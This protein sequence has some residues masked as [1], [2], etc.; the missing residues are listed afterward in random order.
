MIPYRAARDRVVADCA[1]IGTETLAIGD[2]L[3]R[4]LAEAVVAADPVPPFANTAMDGYAV[5]AADV[6]G[7][8]ATEPARLKVIGTLAAGAAPTAAVAPGEALR[9]M[10]GAPFPSGADAIVHRRGHRG[11]RRRRAGARARGAGEFIRAAGRGHR[12]RVGG[13]RGPGRSSDLDISGCWPVSG[14]A[15]V[16]VF[17]RR[18]GRGA[19]DRRRAG[20]ASGPLRLGQIR[21]SNRR[22]LLALLAPGRVRAGR[23]GHRPGRRGRPSAPPSRRPWPVRRRPDQRWGEHGGL[24][25][26]QEGARRNRRDGLDAGGHPAGQAAGLRGDAG[27]RRC[28]GCPATRCRRW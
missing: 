12:R 21:D 25:L 28:S 26:R 8:T 10:T 27:P 24:R 1:I 22:T 18:P 9:I 14:S 3:G 4:V 7:A 2:A 17:R 6:A 23:P 11:R 20:R 15:Q 19:V 13:V 5:R 16:S